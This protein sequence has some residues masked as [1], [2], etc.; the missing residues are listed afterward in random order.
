M[1]KYDVILNELK[2]IRIDLRTLTAVKTKVDNLQWWHRK[3][4]GAI[5]F[6]I[7]SGLAGVITIFIKGVL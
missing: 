3:I 6:A 2:E 7:V 4:I 1:S 5:I